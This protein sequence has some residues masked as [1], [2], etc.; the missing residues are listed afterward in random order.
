MLVSQSLFS[1][2][3]SSPETYFWRQSRLW[4]E[5]VYE[6]VSNQKLSLIV[7]KYKVL[8]FIRM[9]KKGRESF[10]VAGQARHADR[11]HGGHVRRGDLAHAARARHARAPV[12]EARGQRACTGRWRLQES[13]MWSD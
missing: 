12:L 1:K 8:I 7:S 3:S 2:C 9:I 10:G 4:H 11:T 13:V 6:A 5:E